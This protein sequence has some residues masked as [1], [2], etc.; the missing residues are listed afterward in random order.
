MS[1]EVFEHRMSDTF[2]GYDWGNPIIPWYEIR[3]ELILDHLDAQQKRKPLTGE[4]ILDELEWLRDGGM[5]AWDALQQLGREWRSTSRL[6][7]RYRRHDLARW[8]EN[9]FGAEKWRSEKAA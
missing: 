6:C 7:S 2:G 4:E 9:C 1:A 5:S 8:L 3:D